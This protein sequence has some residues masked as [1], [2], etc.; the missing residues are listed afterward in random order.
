MADKAVTIT[1]KGK[2]YTLEFSRAV[3]Q[4]MER[5]QFSL[6][7]LSTYPNVTIPALVE[8]AFRMHHP[9]IKKSL[10]DEIFNA[11][12][13]KSDFVLKLAQLYNEPGNALMAEPEEG[14]EGNVI[15]TANW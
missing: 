14:N 6:D 2:D 12:P 8:G 5:S 4:T 1:Y 15:W 3:V 9:T 11:I 10:V 7:N 13:Q